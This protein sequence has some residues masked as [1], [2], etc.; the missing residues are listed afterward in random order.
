MSTETLSAL[1]VRTFG[2]AQREYGGH[3]QV[4]AEDIL[5]V[6]FT[7]EGEARAHI[8]KMDNIFVIDGNP[9]L[10]RLQAQFPEL[11][12]FTGASSAIN[13][14]ILVNPS[15]VVSVRDG[16]IYEQT[17]DIYTTIAD[18]VIPIA[19]TVEEVKNKLG[20]PSADA[21]PAAQP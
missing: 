6:A 7:E 10:Q 2:S 4:H 13:F 3:P 18:I 11:K 17:A 5:Y 21:A 15:H 1:T 9:T 12:L 19:G 8:V 14:P 20:L 16:A